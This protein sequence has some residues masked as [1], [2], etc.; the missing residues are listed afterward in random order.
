MPARLH[1]LNLDFPDPFPLYFVV[2]LHSGC[3]QLDSFQPLLLQQGMFPDFLA[4]FTD[5]F[6]SC[7]C[8][9]LASAAC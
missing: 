9:V 2:G 3:A 7:T 8:Y 6:F 4:V 5:F 1:C